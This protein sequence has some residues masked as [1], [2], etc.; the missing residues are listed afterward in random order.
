MNLQKINRYKISED[1]FFKAFQLER[2]EYTIKVKNCG[3]IK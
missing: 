1:A 2:K 3:T